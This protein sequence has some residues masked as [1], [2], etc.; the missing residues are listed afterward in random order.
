MC[1]TTRTS[2]CIF[3]TKSASPSAKFNSML[4]SGYDTSVEIA[5]GRGCMFTSLQ[6][7]FTVHGMGLL[8]F[9]V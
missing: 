3:T 7:L 6:V 5:F 4:S 2:N 8:S 9:L 1:H